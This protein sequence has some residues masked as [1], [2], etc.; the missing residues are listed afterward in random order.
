MD[1]C[2]AKS[3][4]MSKTAIALVLIYSQLKIHPDYNSDIS[5]VIDHMESSKTSVLLKTLPSM[6][7]V[8]VA[9]YGSLHTHVTTQ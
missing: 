5:S 7:L 4:S 3:T 9:S 6:F 1:G 2:I 8:G